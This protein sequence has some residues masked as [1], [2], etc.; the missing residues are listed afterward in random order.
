[1]K[2]GAQRLRV[3]EGMVEG[4]ADGAVG[5]RK[6]RKRLGPVDDSRPDRK[7]FEPEALAVPHQRRRR[8]AVHLED[9]AGPWAHVASLVVLAGRGSPALPGASGPDPALRMSK[10]IFTAPRR[11][12]AAAWATASS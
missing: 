8:R 3:T 7:L 9:E 10:T 11:P 12:A 2:K 4:L 5:I 6:Q 1:M